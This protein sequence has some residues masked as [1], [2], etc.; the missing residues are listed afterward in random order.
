MNTPQRTGATAMLEDGHGRRITHLRLA[1]HGGSGAH[2]PWLEHAELAQLCGVLARLGVGQVRLT[3]DEP[4]LRPGLAELAGRI[5]A[6]PGVHTLALSTDGRRLARHAVALRLAGVQRLN[7][8]LGTLDA[9]R[10]RQ[11]E[12]VDALC[13]VLGGL[14]AARHAGFAPIKINCAVRADTTEAALA[15]MLAWTLAGG[16]I[17]RL[18]DEGG[19]GSVHGAAA[20]PALAARLAE[21]FGLIAALESR[22]SGPAHYWTAGERARALGVINARTRQHAEALNRVYMTPD[23][24]LHLGAAAAHRLPL[25]AMLRAGAGE[26]E[27]AES[28]VRG[29]AQRPRHPELG[30]PPAVLRRLA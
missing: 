4:L 21:R 11:Q 9:A 22:D 28:I 26:D 3:G 19:Y 8:A 25:G 29:V 18:I 5:S 12:G 23:G 27:L 24:T 30:A 7:V 16:F 20:L 14:R 1:V 15:R 6:L 13:D 2:A 17:L 10:Y